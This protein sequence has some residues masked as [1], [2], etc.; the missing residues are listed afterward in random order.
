MVGDERWLLH[1]VELRDGVWVQH[2]TV[3]YRSG[4]AEIIGDCPDG[5]PL[6]EFR[7]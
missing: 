4:T 2:D 1:A 3:A 6:W 7:L 5:S